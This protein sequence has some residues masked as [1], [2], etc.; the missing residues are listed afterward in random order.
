MVSKKA[1][2]TRKKTK[3]TGV[4]SV[5]IDGNMLRLQFPSS[6]SQT[7]WGTRQKYKALG[8]PNTP[9]NMAKAKE[10]AAI[11]ESDILKDE[12]DISL[13]KYN[14]RALTKTIEKIQPNLP[15]LL[16]FCARYFEE[17]VKPTIAPGTQRRYKGYLK[18]ME[19]CS[20]ADIIKDAVQIKDSIRAVRNAS[21]TRKILNLIYKVVQWGKRNGLIPKSAENPYKE[22][23]QDVIGQK[24]YEK[25]KHIQAL[26]DEDDDDDYRAFSKGEA[27]EII[28]R[29]DYHGQPNGIYKDLVKF[30][31]LTGC[32]TSEAI[33]L[34]W[35]D[36]SDDCGELIF[37]HSYCLHSKKLKGLKTE[38]H[39]K[40]SRKFPCGEKLKQLLLKLR[41]SQTE[42]L[43]PKS[44]IFHRHGKP[45]FYGSFRNCWAGVTAKKGGVLGFLIKVG[46]VKNY[47]KPYATRHSFITWQLG[48][49]Q[50]PANVAK[51]VGNSPEMI[52]KHYVS[53]DEDAKV[54]FE[55]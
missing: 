51:L 50:T 43:N 34:R 53:A 29:F 41:D 42:V 26:L 4:V 5:G 13:E 38:R 32:R 46:K 37:R 25:P 36:V 47:L 3:K 14:P 12:L 15:K 35:M 49:G 8:L 45:I 16:E 27:I 18:G 20:D 44:F 11:A 2:S 33:G 7:I 6:V 17:I 55:I 48:A 23:T 1:T 28:E 31:F 9:E 21:A 39:G 10:I 54:V 24:K 22:L 52:Y 30:L 19:Q 40:A